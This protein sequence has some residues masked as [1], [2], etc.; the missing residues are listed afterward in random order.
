M[1]SLQSQMQSLRDNMSKVTEEKNL[2][3]KE[4]DV[5]SQELQEK[6]RTVTQVK[7]IGR[8]YKTQYDE[9]KV[10]HDRVRAQPLM[11]Q[12]FPSS[13]LDPVTN[14]LYCL[15][16][17]VAQAAA[18]PSQDEARQAS[19]QEL[20]SLRESLNQAEAKTK[21]LEGQLENINKV[22]HLK[23]LKKTTGSRQ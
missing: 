11:F 17:M 23:S 12:L 19:V 6:V 5:K 8:R 2:L 22:A 7:K 3:K 20:Q 21:E 14:Q 13:L 4:V 9:L 16:Q 15:L 1:A 10:E 18:G